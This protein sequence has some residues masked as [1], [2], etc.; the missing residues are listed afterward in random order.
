MAPTPASDD[1]PPALLANAMGEQFRREWMRSNDP[2]L[3]DEAVI[4]FREASDLGGAESDDQRSVFFNSLAG[5]LGE[6]FR[7]R[8]DLADLEE[9]KTTYEAADAL[10]PDDSGYKKMIKSNLGFCLNQLF[11]RTNDAAYV[12][13]SARSFRAA[14]A[15]CDPRS[16]E[17]QSIAGMQA[18]VADRAYRLSTDPTYLD[19][20]IEA[21]EIA[22]GG[23]DGF[24]RPQ[25]LLGQFA[26]LLIERYQL[27]HRDEDLDAA[28]R[29]LEQRLEY[30]MPA[31]ERVLSLAGIAH[32]C[33]ISLGRSYSITVEAKQSAAIDEIAAL[34]SFDTPQTIDNVTTVGQACQLL[35]T[36]TGRIEQWRRR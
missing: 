24:K 30:A 19:W 18:A 20:A 31:S 15:L 8:G 21:Y 4:A 26:Q 36:A 32:L 9:A 1:V 2:A 34:G 3:L 28:M 6:R 14:L 23:L 27:R 17:A 11:G 10:T 35:Y 12:I 13:A 22:A 29:R 7:V 5:M 16:D 25:M 33:G